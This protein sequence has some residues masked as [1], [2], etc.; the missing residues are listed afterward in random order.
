MLRKKLV[1]CLLLIL[2]LFPFAFSVQATEDNRERIESFDSKINISSESLV[3]VEETIKYFFPEARHG[4]IRKIPI[5]YNL[6][7]NGKSNETINVKFTLKSVNEKKDDGTITSVPFTQAPNGSDQE[8]KIGD[9][10]QTVTGFITYVISYEVIRVINFSPQGNENQDEFYWNITGNRWEV[11]IKSASSDIT[12]PS[13]IDPKTWNFACF[14]GETSSSAKECSFE[15][16][17]EK[18]VH[19]K[20]LWEL[21][22]L[23][24]LTEISGLPK[25][26]LTPPKENPVSL[27]WEKVTTYFF[28]FLPLVAFIA[29]FINW[30]LRGRDPKGKGTIIP[31]YSAPDNLTPT[32]IG[33]LVDEKADLKDISASIIDFAV[34]GAIKIKEIENKGIF[35][36]FKGKNDYE[37]ILL[38]RDIFMPSPEKEIFE[39]IFP[40]DIV[41]LKN[42]SN[43]GGN[44]IDLIS[45]GKTKIFNDRVKLS[46]LQDRFPQKINDLK[47]QIYSGLV[48][49][50]YFPKSPQRVRNVYLIIGII[51]AF[52]GFIFLA[53]SMSILVAGSTAVT[54]LLVAIFGF[55]MPKKTIKGVDVY[56]KILGLKEYMTVAEK[57]RIEFHS[58]P[59]KRPETFEKLLPYAMVLGVEKEWA[60]QFETIYLSQPGWYEGANPGSTF[61]TIY[62]ASALSNFG[63]VANTSMGIKTEGAGAAGGLSGFGGGG[64]SGGGFGGGGGGSW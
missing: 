32:E 48:T 16:T 25:G 18:T 51:L 14:T 6:T 39:I 56:E 34:K 46:E 21:P 8:I 49:K 10:N 9:P 50:G 20:S 29:L 42:P 40:G 4:I 64:F 3:S 23:S 62:F 61:N 45:E 52:L 36:F 24:G 35:G 60:K 43:L 30:F 17:S 44:V 5:K 59:A 63:S 53:N 22:A 19:F 33:T 38:K 1:F 13:S 31:F 15:A 28:L 27:F 11:P 2:T 54:G 47:T 58:S 7:K 26:L 12:F 41:E 57:D 55:F 37:L